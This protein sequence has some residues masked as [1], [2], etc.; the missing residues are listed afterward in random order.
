MTGYLVHPP[1]MYLASSSSSLP[2]G[3][4]VAVASATVVASP[5]SL[6]PA[7]TAAMPP[8]RNLRGVSGCRTP[9]LLSLP[10]LGGRAALAIA[11][12]AAAASASAA[13][14]H[15]ELDPA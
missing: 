4:P 14:G 9:S 6:A 7:A 15:S 1:Q 2:F 12:A 10:G 3:G 13:G 8:A 5:T 11:A